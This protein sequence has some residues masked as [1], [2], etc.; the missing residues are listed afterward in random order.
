MGK[1]VC[2]RCREVHETDA[3][4]CP[5]C[6]EHAGQS[7]DFSNSDRYLEEEVPRVLEHRRRTGLDG[8]TG[9][10][11]YVV[12]NTEP[13][14]LLPA[15]REL[16]SRTGHR[17]AGGFT[18]SAGKVLVLEREGSAGI[19]VK[20]RL[21]RE[22]PFRELNR[23]PR[24]AHLPNTRL[25]TLIFSVSDLDAYH[26]IQSAEGREFTTD[27]VRDFDGYRYLQTAPSRYTGNALGFVQWTGGRGTFASVGRREFTWEAPEPPGE[28][29]GKVGF[30]DHMA[31]RVRAE[32][33]DRA[34]IEFMELTSYTFDF[35]VYVKVFNSIT[36]VA[37]LSPDDFAM[38]FTSGI[39]PFVSMEE[40]GPTE[41]FIENYGPRVHHMAFSTEDIQETFRTF[42]GNGQQFMIDL[43]G[44]EE[45]GLRQTFTEPSEH[46]M[47]VNEYIHRYR[48]FDGFFTRSNITLLTGATEKQ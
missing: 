44:S 24:S 14:R 22:N 17:P 41:K 38:V 39:R 3:G 10:L 11:E 29:E 4:H 1:V 45:E 7:Y 28:V 40:S 46:T 27:R 12:I 2:G 19:L 34:I 13:D 26:R 20:H 48:G 9:G 42:L 21:D 16:A 30:L 6:G 23:R 36:N 37:R 35:A 43:V 25:E 15:A 5:V 47:L 32:D 8:L 31:T 33:R 18:D